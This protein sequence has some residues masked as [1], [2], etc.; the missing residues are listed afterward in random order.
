M[1][2]SE[3]DT[4]KAIEQ[5]KDTL[6]FVVHKS[7][8]MAVSPYFS[9]ALDGRFSDAESKSLSLD[10]DTDPDVF[11]TFLEWLYS[12]RLLA[13]NGAEDCYSHSYG[14][15]I[16][17]YIFA[18][19]YDIPKLR[20]DIMSLVW[21]RFRGERCPINETLVGRAFEMLSP[22]S[23][24]S[25]F[26]LDAWVSRGKADIIQQIDIDSL[27]GEGGKIFL[28]MAWEKSVKQSE[29]SSSRT[30]RTTGAAHAS[31][32]MFE[33][34]QPAR[35]SKKLKNILA[36]NRISPA[37][38]SPCEYH[39]HGQGFEEARCLSDQLAHVA[40]TPKHEL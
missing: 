11:Q 37:L 33:M 26:L 21:K 7:H 14:E 38:V 5:E 22:K 2:L 19:R 8:L 34:P 25:R 30:V 31:E 10:D 17:L 28:K 20:D 1:I 40:F 24:M 29:G 15:L 32:W 23:T 18:D 16:E 39:E 9:N 12:R 6:E 4:G 3:D 36:P 35:R 13:A 27:S